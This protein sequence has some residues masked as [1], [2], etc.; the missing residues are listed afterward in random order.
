[1]NRDDKR[2]QVFVSSTYRDLIDERKEVMQALLEL[3]CIP[4]GMELFQAADEDQWTLIRRVIDDCDYYMVIVAGR[5]GSIGMG[6]LSYTEM[7]YRYATERGKPIVA[8]LYDKPGN[9]EVDKSESESDRR[10][11]L[12]AFRS[13]CELKV[14]K[15]WNGP[16][17]LGSVVSRSIVRLIKERPTVG[18]IRGSAISSEEANREI[19]RLRQEVDELQATLSTSATKRPDGI[20]NLLQ[21]G[22]MIPAEARLRLYKK[23]SSVAIDTYH[24]KVEVPFDLIFKTVGPRLLDELPEDDFES[25]VDDAF[26]THIAPLLAKTEDFKGRKI[27]GIVSTQESFQNIKVQFVALGLVY[28]GIK[29]RT[30]SDIRTYWKLTP[31]GETKLM[32]ILAM[33]RNTA[34]PLTA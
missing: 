29:K 34:L 33:K 25:S 26:Y 31:Y 20:D 13:L 14:V 18:W 3:D 28:K 16:Q 1:M 12:I 22:D 5:Y 17:S 27:K 9:I 6:G 21:E 23:S 32:S 24:R 30:V 15:Y 2:Y 8:F 19:L 4:S 7:E 10:E 11:Q